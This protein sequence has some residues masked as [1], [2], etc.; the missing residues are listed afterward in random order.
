MT[1]VLG[2]QLGLDAGTNSR[3]GY[4]LFFLNGEEQQ[5]GEL[6]IKTTY[7]DKYTRQAPNEPTQIQ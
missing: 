3:E 4:V 6:L 5:T 1:K 2:W 7:V